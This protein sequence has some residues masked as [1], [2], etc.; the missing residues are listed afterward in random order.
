MNIPTGG[1]NEPVPA[2]VHQFSV[3]KIEYSTF[4]Q[5][6]MTSSLNSHLIFTFILLFF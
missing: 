5:L 3:D 1:F 2:R 4:R 6:I